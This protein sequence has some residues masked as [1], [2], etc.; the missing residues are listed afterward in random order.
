MLYLRNIVE[1][2]V[3]DGQL[4]KQHGYWRWTGD[5]A[6]PPSLVELI[7]AR[8]GALPTS[9]SDVVDVLA[10]GEPIEMASLRQIAD[11]A[12]VEEADRRGL[13][14][15][16]PIARRCGSPAGASAL[17]RGAPLDARHRSPL[18]RLRGLV[19]AELAASD[20]R[21]DMRVVVRRATLSLDSDLDART[22]DLSSGQPGAP[23]G[24]RICSLRIG[25]RKRPS[26]P[27]RV[28]RR[29]CFPPM[30]F[31]GWAVARRLT[32]CWRISA[33]AS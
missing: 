22:D 8:I 6:M 2:G 15:L 28:R 13:I 26:V 29:L 5:P 24:L 20:D 14:A 3:A 33:P 23:S 31:R 12:A 1:Q 30:L 17:R 19:V 7:E 9:V 32:R 27:A 21:D 18:R 25:S 11:P 16:D 10:V 4:A